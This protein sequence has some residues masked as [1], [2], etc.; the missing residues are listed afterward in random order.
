MAGGDSSGSARLLSVPE[1]VREEVGRTHRSLKLS[2][3]VVR[4]NRDE[5][6]RVRTERG[7]IDIRPP[8]GQKPPDKGQRVEI[9]IRPSRNPDQ[10]PETATIRPAPPQT[11]TPPA[12][13]R[14]A[15][16]PVR[17]EIDTAAPETRPATTASGAT[18]PPA[19]SPAPEDLAGLIVRLTPV[20]SGQQAAQPAAISVPAPPP[21]ANPAA[22]A[23]LLN[24][25]PLPAALPAAT[26]PPLP[27]SAAPPQSP[28]GLAQTISE[29]LAQPA[30]PSLT[31]SGSGLVSGPV[32]EAPGVLI[33]PPPQGAPSTPPLFPGQ[34]LP[35][36]SMAIL[37]MRI[38][39]AFPP[40]SPALPA[41][42]LP[43][44][45][46]EAGAADTPLNIKTGVLPSPVQ[47]PPETINAIVTG[48]T[49]ANFPIVTIFPSGLT[50][51]LSA[52]S[53]QA[54]IMAIPGEN[55]PIGTQL[56]LTPQILPDL[57]PGAPMSAPSPFPIP[58]MPGP[59]PVMDE[60]LQNIMQL[61]PQATQTL[62]NIIPSPANPVQMSPA[63]LFFLAAVRGGD[64][65]QWI[66]ERAVETLRREG[67][68]PILSRLAQESSA[69]N[70]LAAEP[71]PQEWRAVTLPMYHQGEIHK[72]ALHY[73]HERA[74]DDGGE[75]AG[76]LR[77]TRFVFDLS[78]N[79]MGRV[80]VDGLFRP[81]S[82]AGKRLDLVLR[83]EQ[84]FSAHAQGDM[85]QIYARALR[86]TQITG[87]LSFQNRPEQWFVISAAPGRSPGV[88]A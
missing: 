88:S 7:D 17:I 87:E 61:S 25:T 63:M 33:P 24:T 12:P 68:A 55:I 15:S 34:P 29:F 58:A 18:P 32:P 1:N 37:N 81:V 23:P 27:L 44:A 73:R 84:V 72:I 2:G 46:G 60:L 65:T 49:T 3:E 30:A 50:P 39:A 75:A 35:A 66:G 64:L 4:E 13:D 36:G 57:A 28:V 41:F 67:R 22:D 10:P 51:E 86:D 59:W 70:R 8:E 21:P 5:S 80:Q 16:T 79:A 9:E 31:P 19:T 26:Q 69:L 78:L 83:T 76:G 6:V 85:R 42:A 71:L 56:Q 43:D 40:S 11:P 74:P 14:T 47:P 20:S 62:I 82:S 52:E 45:G 77:G 54:F 38:E 48:K 53:G